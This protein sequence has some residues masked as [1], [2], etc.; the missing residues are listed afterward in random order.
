VQ[1]AVGWVLREMANAY[2]SEVRAY[3]EENIGTISA[4]ALRRATERAGPDAKAE[5]RA[6]RAAALA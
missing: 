6:L 3:L 2:P 5:L 4:V 1:K